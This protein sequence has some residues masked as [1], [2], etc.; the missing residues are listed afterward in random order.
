MLA[1]IFTDGRGTHGEP[2]CALTPSL[3]ARPQ[4]QSSW[5][6]LERISNDSLNSLGRLFERLWTG[7]L[8]G[9]KD[10][11]DCGPPRLNQFLE[12]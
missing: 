7:V 9:Q 11:V 6:S 1:R 10:L 8:C 5:R 3:K 4:I 12:E 2:C